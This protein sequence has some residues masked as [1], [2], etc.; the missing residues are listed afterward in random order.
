MSEHV[1]IDRIRRVL[2]DEDVLAHLSHLHTVYEAGEDHGGL[3]DDE[4]SEDEFRRAADIEYVMTWLHPNYISPSF[5]DD[6]VAQW[7]AKQKQD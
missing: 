5:P 6:W 1:D 2:L 4:L 3:A 7:R